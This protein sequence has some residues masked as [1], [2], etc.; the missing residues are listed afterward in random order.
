MNL[1]ILLPE[2][3]YWQG[4]VKKVVGEAKNGSF[5]L[6]PAHVDFVTIMV[7]GIFYTVTEENQDLYLAINEGIL[8]KTGSEVTLATRNAVK[9]E[10]LGSLKKQV[11]EDFKKINQQDRGARNALQKLEAD[12]VRRFL[13]LEA[14]E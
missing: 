14:H 6:L 4:R 3:T 1:T 11:E 2:K 5:C 13:D 9:G 8:L 12:F 10:N 7:P